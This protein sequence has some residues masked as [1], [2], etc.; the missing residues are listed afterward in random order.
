MRAFVRALLLSVTLFG[1]PLVASAQTDQFVT[2]DF[3]VSGLTLTPP[4][5]QR[6]QACFFNVQAT[7]R[8]VD[9]SVSGEI[10]LHFRFVQSAPCDETGPQTFTATGTFT[11]SVA[12]TAGSFT[13]RFQ[14]HIDAEEHARGELV[15]LHGA[16]GLEDLHGHLT[17]TGQSGVG[18]VYEGRVS[19]GKEK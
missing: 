9:G 1:I 12:G 11:G 5:R 8:F 2:G 15:I 19:F 14:G 13:V 10:P 4:P 6:G 17:L 16:G 18:G 3:E 7:F